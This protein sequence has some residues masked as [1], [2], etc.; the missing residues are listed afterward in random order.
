LKKSKEQTIGESIRIEKELPE[1]ERDH[2]E[3]EE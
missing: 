3:A 1:L 2:A